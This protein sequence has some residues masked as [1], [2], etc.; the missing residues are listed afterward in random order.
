[1]AYFTQTADISRVGRNFIKPFSSA[2]GPGR[3]FSVKVFRVEA[4][5]DVEIAVSGG[6]NAASVFEEGAGVYNL[7]VPDG[8]MSSPN[9]YYAM[10]SD[11]VTGEG[12]RIP[13]WSHLAVDFDDLVH[14]RIGDAASDLN[15]LHGFNNTTNK[16]T[17][18]AAL[19]KALEYGEHAKTELGDVSAESFTG[20]SAPAD[21]AKALAAIYNKVHTETEAIDSA[22]TTIDN[23]IGAMQGNVTSILADTNE[24][25]TDWANGGR[26]DLLLDKTVA[27]SE[28]AEDLIGLAAD[29]SSAATVFGKIAL[30]KSDLTTEI[31]ANEAKLDTIDGV[32][33]G[34]AAEIGDVSAVFGGGSPPAT[35]AAALKTIYDAQ[36]SAADVWDDAIDG[37]DPA[38]SAGKR[39]YDLSED[40]KNGGR[41]DLI[42]D[43]AAAD[44]DA[45]RVSAASAD[46]KLGTAGA[47]QTTVFQEIADLSS[48]VAGVQDDTT[49]ILGAIG[50]VAGETLVQRLAAIKSIVDTLTAVGQ[51]ARLSLY[52]PERI[53]G[54]RTAN[55]A[56]L[57]SLVSRNE[58]GADDDL[59]TVGNGRAFMRV[60]GQSGSPLAN[61]LY[62]DSGLSTLAT[63]GSDAAY[64]G[65]AVM[66]ANGASNAKFSLYFKAEPKDNESFTFEATGQDSDGAV[67]RKVTAVKQMVVTSTF[68]VAVGGA[69]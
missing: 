46:T 41:L 48:E 44:A 4:G 2:F 32:V 63:A 11:N 43:E 8:A 39:L 64:T 12:I 21:V 69:F 62:T 59:E 31:N 23:E 66:T 18:A 13:M 19:K 57:V 6:A 40:W 16:A 33:D 14:Q 52:C 56:V 25:Q 42:L 36:Q 67:I 9:N 27:A 37:T 17:V 7:T 50:T 60:L 22:L 28:A 1:M 65:Y 38:G 47:G 49:E 54:F 29:T 45:A 5:A 10:L 34:I 53:S 3:T 55:L 20:I 26:L 24:L 15:G 30:L 61:R 68:A 35:V 58:V 51:A